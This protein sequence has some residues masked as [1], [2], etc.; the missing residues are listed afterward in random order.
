MNY[1][2]WLNIQKTRVTT[3][4]SQK[5]ISDGINKDICGSFECF[6]EATAKIKYVYSLIL[7]SAISK[8]TPFHKF[9]SIDRQ[10]DKGTNRRTLLLLRYN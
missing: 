10:T 6:K 1:K 7:S 8:T 4:M 2:S 9:N 5:T 3:S